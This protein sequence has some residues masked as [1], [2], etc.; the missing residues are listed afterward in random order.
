[1]TVTVCR[2]IPG[3]GKSTWAREQVRQSKG[4]TKRI[5][6]D[7][8]RAMLDDSVWSKG[9]EKQIVAVRNML[10]FRF[11]DE[12]FSVIIDDTNV[13][14]G[15]VN[16]IRSLVLQ[17]FPGAE[18][19]VK[20]FDVPLDVCLERNAKRTGIAHVPEHVVRNFHNKLREALSQE[21][22]EEWASA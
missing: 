11:L 15:A 2:G 17:Q 21:S 9:N 3:S 16:E 8:L 1:M 14:A 22:G 18:F 19:Q 12:G 20:L 6:R 5:N 10:L 4:E 13:T 7:D